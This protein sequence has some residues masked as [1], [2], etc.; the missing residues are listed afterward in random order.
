M[1]A[2]KTGQH[3]DVIIHDDL[4]TEENS[5]NP[6]QRKKILRHYKMNTSILEPDGILVV[7]GTRYA[8]DDVIGHILDNEIGDKNTT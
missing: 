2:G 6:D 1:G 5:D 3:Y 7:I 8:T 4:N